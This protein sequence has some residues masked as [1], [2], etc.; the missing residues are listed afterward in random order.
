MAK[1]EGD[2]TVNGTS[3]SLG[4]GSTLAGAVKDK[5]VLVTGGCGFIGY[6]LVRRLLASGA[7]VNVLDNLSSGRRESL[8]DSPALTFYQG[9]VMEPKDLAEPAKGADMV[10]HLA[11]VVGMK[12]AASDPEYTYNVSKDGTQNVLDATPGL[13][14]VLFSSSAVYGLNRGVSSEDEPVNEAATL[15]YDSGKPGYAFGKYTL[16]QVGLAEAEKTGRPLLLIRPFN[17]VG[18]RQR[19]AYG[20]VLPN[21]IKNCR[22]GKPITLYDDGQ[23][24]R[25]FSHVYTFLDC[26]FKL[27]DRPDAFRPPLNIVNIGTTQPTTI[28]DLARIVMEVTGREVPLEYVPYTEVFHG[29]RDVRFRLPRIERLE[30]LIGPVKWPD[31]REVVQSINDETPAGATEGAAA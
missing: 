7:Q 10:F 25:S 21:F 1:S 29:K 6:H 20:M 23:M 3:A 31:I 13:P 16:E 27:L 17:V 19:S 2:N 14:A 26:L 11:S 15:E 5:R 4:A 22:A 30:S 18:P 12:L 8:P 9:S 28:M 24:V